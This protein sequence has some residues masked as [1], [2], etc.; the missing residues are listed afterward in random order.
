MWDACRVL[1][2]ATVAALQRR[3]TCVTMSTRSRVMPTVVAMLLLSLFTLWCRW[4][5]LL[6]DDGNTRPNLTG[7]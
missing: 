6:H 5:R 4:R 1:V 2:A 3:P 7:H